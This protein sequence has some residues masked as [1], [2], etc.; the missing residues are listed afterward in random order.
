MSN[1]SFCPCGS[2]RRLGECCGRFIDGPALPRTAEQLMRSRYTAYALGRIDYLRATWHAS[3]CPPDLAPDLAVKWI[4]LRILST[5]AGGATDETGHVEFVAR[6]KIQG[7]AHRLY[8]RSR[9]LLED[10]LWRYL[11]GKLDGES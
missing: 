1:T 5:E 9:F 11:D 6:Y 10:G 3:T 2:D 4:G 8:E 7:R